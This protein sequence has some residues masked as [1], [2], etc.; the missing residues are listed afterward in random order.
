MASLADRRE[1]TDKGYH[2]GSLREEA[3]SPRGS[4]IY[5][6]R[7]DAKLN[8]GRRK[9]SRQA[10]SGY[11]SLLPE[12]FSMRGPAHVPQG[13]VTGGRWLD[14]PSNCSLLPFA[15]PRF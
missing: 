15:L 11:G 8:K 12:G 5:L 10:P 4:W 13:Q 3:A 9:R 7:K 6:R 2:S 1:P 14:I